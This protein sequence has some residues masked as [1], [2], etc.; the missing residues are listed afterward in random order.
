MGEADAGKV[1]ELTTE[2][3]KW[4]TLFTGKMHR[5]ESLVPE[6]EEEFEQMRLESRASRIND[7][8]AGRISDVVG[9]KKVRIDVSTIASSLH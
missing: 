3:G 2:E 6:F 9:I 7:L 1:A 8:P 4:W 5:Y